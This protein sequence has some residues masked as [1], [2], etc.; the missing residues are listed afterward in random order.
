MSEISINYINFIIKYI[1]II[2]E[3]V[4]NTKIGMKIINKYFIGNSSLQ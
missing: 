1:H 2:F 4:E 3:Y